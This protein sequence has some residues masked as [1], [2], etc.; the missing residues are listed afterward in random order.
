ML[1]LPSGYCRDEGKSK[2]RVRRKKKSFPRRSDVSLRL[3]RCWSSSG[4][5]GQMLLRI[6]K[7]DGWL[8]TG[9]RETRAYISAFLWHLCA[10]RK[11]VEPNCV[12]VCVGKAEFTLWSPSGSR[13][14]DPPLPSQQAGLC[15]A[16]NLT[17]RA[18]C[19]YCLAAR[20]AF[21]LLLFQRYYYNRAPTKHI[22][23]LSWLWGFHSYYLKKKAEICEKHC[24]C[25]SS[26]RAAW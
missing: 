12:C 23:N 18:L 26:E 24:L 11:V 22:V 14:H 8:L 9:W 6:H 16:S 20:C 5:C 21:F 1:P 13:V 7:R 15:A 10:F 2:D 17:G 4:C 3:H 19:P 25:G